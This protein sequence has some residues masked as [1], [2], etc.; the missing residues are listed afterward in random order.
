MP[1]EDGEFYYHELEGLQVESVKG[2][3]LGILTEVLPTGANDVYV[4]RGPQGEL[5]I[6][7]SMRWCW[8]STS[9]KG[10]SSCACRMGSAMS[11]LL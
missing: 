5:L 2:Q 6:P 3:A 9:T 8:R 7:P 1:L 4:V 10:A 11:E